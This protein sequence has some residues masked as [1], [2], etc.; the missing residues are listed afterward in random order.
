MNRNSRGQWAFTLIELLVVIAII[1][2]LASLLLPVLAKAKQKAQKI[3]CINNLRQ[4]GLA[5]YL[6]ATDNGDILP[7]DGMGANGQYAPD[8]GWSGE[9]YN[10]TTGTPDDPYAWFNASAPNVGYKDGYSNYYHLPGG[11][12]RLK[13]PLPGHKNASA[14]IWY[15]P[16]A[17]MSDGDFAQLSGPQGAY[18]FFSYAD[19]ID[20]KTRTIGGQYPH[21]MPRLGALKK[22]SATVLMF[23][24]V[25]N[26]VT[27]IVN[28]SPG[29]NSVNPANRYRSV[30]VRHE[31]GT[32]MNF[33]DG[34]SSYYKI[35]YLTNFPGYPGVEPKLDDVIWDWKV[36]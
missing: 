26:P 13:Y 27:E 10:F 23:D 20:L 19:N 31:K 12:P 28:G 34:H 36:R 32:V 15:C 8:A 6:T 5:Q 17:T 7:N 4:W 25:F 11:D 1:A 24:V 21:W 33:C 30:G 18:G 9:G 22:P 3:D 2:I 16:S 35:H 14:R 29:Y